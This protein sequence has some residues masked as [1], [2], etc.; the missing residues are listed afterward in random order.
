[1]LRSRSS[2]L[3]AALVTASALAFGAL[4]ATA[5]PA[6]AAS[7]IVYDSI[8]DTLAPNYP[9]LGFQATSTDE[10]GDIVR[11]AGS[12]RRLTSATVVL[13]SWACETGGGLSCVTEPGATYDHD[14]TFAVYG[15]D[16]SGA[17][18]AP[19]A[20]L[21]SVTE[22]KQIPFR[23]SASAACGDGRWQLPSV[24]TCS[25]GL[26]FPLTFD[27]SALGVY[28]PDEIAVTVA[29]DTNTNGAHPI[30]A[31]GP[32]ESLNVVATGTAPTVGTEVQDEVLW[33]TSNA[34]FYA[35]GGDAGTDTLR[36]DTGWTGNG[37]LMLELDT[38][39]SLVPAP[40]H[41]VTVRQR[42]VAPTENA[43]TYQ[44]W[45]EGK[46]TPHFEVKADGLHLGV[47]GSST[48]IKGT[49]V[50]TIPEASKVTENELRQLITGIAS[51]TVASGS[52]TVQVPVFYGDGAPTGYTT[53]HTTVGAGT[54]TFSTSDDAWR[55]SRAL[56]S[57]PLQ[58]EDT[59]GALLDTLF[60]QGGDVWLAGFGVQADA[61][62]VVES[63]TW[64]D[65]VYTFEQPVVVPCTSG[66]TAGPL[67]T[68]SDPAG[69]DFSQTRTA[70][71]NTFTADGLR[72]TTIGATSQ[73]KAAG[74]R[75]IDIALSEVGTPEMTLTQHSGGAPSIQLGV[76]L[77]AD[78]DQDGY[79]VREE[80]YA[81]G[82]WWASNPIVSG[83]FTG[84]PSV[85]GGGSAV[86]GT[87]DQ[88]LVA[89]PD[90]RVLS[91]GYSLGSGLAG[92]ATIHTL[93]VGCASSS[94][95]YTLDPQTSRLFGPDRY[96][97]AIQFS[98]DFAPGLDRVYL[99]S[100]EKFPDALS[101]GAA[102]A[103]MGAPVL[104]T[105]STGLLPSV[106]T[107]L[108]RLH[109]DQIVVLGG[110][111]TLAA[112]IDSALRNL[113]FEPEVTRLAG[114]DRFE[115][116]RMI[117]AEAFGAAG[118]E[119]V[120][121]G[122]GLNFPDALTAGPAAASQHAPVILVDGLRGTLDGD[123]LQLLEDLGTENV[124]I[125]GGNASVTDGIEDQLSVDFSVERLGGADRFEAAVAINRHAF[126]AVEPVAYLATGL[127][128]PDALSGG[129]L[130]AKHGA[131]LFISQEG[132]VPQSVLDALEDLEVT[133][134]VLL[135]GPA[136][137][138]A[139]VEDLVSCSAV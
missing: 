74:Y 118:A 133:S 90:A 26:A 61:E 63:L 15:V 47:G 13:S 124:V 98:G 83:G 79:L 14:I 132:C 106:V 51:V 130:A 17:V 137:L 55:T 97:A 104:L 64:G 116:S 50:G 9:S 59:L 69:W 43:S 7:A 32:F 22:S 107:E 80:V 68:N 33:D 95:D 126:S 102:A 81:P 96:A 111:A 31:N 93:T 52:P 42:D 37:G 48:I 40:A 123:T 75:A 82:M 125:V 30:G 84:L 56:G 131:P 109:P 121:I 101:A 129:A 28:A 135:G 71:S 38:D 105:P 20:L 12:E 21:A 2:R 3:P 27:L 1:M 127:K 58:G 62:A 73:S 139:S 108:N 86:N 35:D 120:Y 87:L 117:T 4:V 39:E 94:F 19:G 122:T 54:T 29:F 23:P 136:S 103:A 89:Y 76:D 138:T 53:L 88:Y 18:A 70:G 119:T 60:A 57:Y 115:V 45:H 128:F 85:G 6:V 72:V 92:D 91:Y 77:D 11:L 44:Q 67:A 66:P 49:D 46:A 8:P 134:V 110:T 99:S 34:G 16:R 10:F 100:G 65:T 36:L 41:E 25:S 114:A 5:A 112:S 78:G 113:P 24:G